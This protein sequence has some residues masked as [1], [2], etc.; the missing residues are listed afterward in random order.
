MAEAPSLLAGLIV[1]ADGQRLTS[2]HAVKASRRYRYYVS[3]S[4][5][6]VRGTRHANQ[7]WR[8]PAGD[9][10]ELV[11]DRL[12]EFFA[13]GQEIRDA[14]SCLKHDDIQ[15]RSACSTALGLADGWAALPTMEI[16]ELVQAIIEKVIVRDE[17]IVVSLRRAVVATR[18]LVFNKA[19]SEIQPGTIELRIDAKLRRAGKGVRLVVGGGIEKPNRPFIAV[20]RAAHAARDALLTG[21]DESIDAVAQRVG[22]K[23]DQLTAQIRMT[24][25]APDIV[26]ALTAGRLPQGLTPARLLSVCRELPH[27]WQRQCAVLGF[28]T[29]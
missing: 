16:R 25:L 23:R 18:L 13:S 21:G 4:H 2:T 7:G 5:L 11:L 22:V 12:R 26:R 27:D 24:Y 15:T 17:E 6:G 1:D 14:L 8:I 20:L 10:E 9:I 3:K 29:R 19:S 28:E